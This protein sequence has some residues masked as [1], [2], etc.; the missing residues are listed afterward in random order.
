M[1]TINN[2]VL[3]N[4]A[5]AGAENLWPQ[6]WALT[7][8]M[9]KAGWKY[10]SSGDGSTKDTSRDPEDD[11]WGSGL[12][13]GVSGSDG[14]LGATAGGRITFTAGSGT[15]F[16]S[17][18]K[19]RFLSITGGFLAVNNHY[20]QIE[21]VVSSTV[22]RL[23]ARNPGFTPTATGETNNGALNYE[24]FD[25]TTETLPGGLAS[26]NAWILMQGPSVIKVPIT[27]APG[28]GVGGL[29]FIRGENISH[30]GT[31]AE[32]EILGWTFSTGSSTGY[33]V[34]LPRVIGTGSA[35]YGWE[36]GGEITGDSSGSAADQQG[37]G[38]EYRQQAVF[39]KAANQNS[40]RI[41]H[42]CIEPVGETA[43]DYYTL[44]QSAGCTAIVP[45]GGGGTG[46]AFP[47][48]GFISCG[49]TT[50]TNS[51]WSGNNGA[52]IHGNA[53]IMCADA[54]WE[55]DYSA[56]GT[57]QW[58][59]A[60]VSTVSSPSAGRGFYR[61]DDTEPGDLDPFIVGGLCQETLYTATPRTE[62]NQSAIAG[63]DNPFNTST[64]AGWTTTVTFWR[65]WRRRGLATGDNFQT[66]EFGS[67]FIGQSTTAGVAAVNTEDTERL[68]TEEDD[69]K[70]RGPLW[71]VSV[72]ANAK[73]RKGTVRHLSIVQGGN[74]WDTYD[75]GR[76]V[77]LSP[78]NGCFVASPW[79]ETS[80]PYP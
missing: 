79:D 22:V 2:V 27:A 57:W 20:H 41:F 71:V 44:S 61:C 6:I 21:E 8:A 9:K 58:Y 36:D 10:L 59:A 72:E 63:A 43:D 47:T 28:P 3:A 40:G 64:Q 37:D 62:A 30:D 55:Q 75:G 53:Q 16:S 7:R 33:L 24:V 14:T 13:T 32:G 80:V 38:L 76:F 49:A 35:P 51:K 74:A 45:P 4:V 68:A 52:L 73:M 77:Q 42:Q 17:G 56:D 1:S 23:D 65:G 46:N 5:N 69:T 39:C 15:P 26:V 50:S 34:V 19:G 18:D 29:T 48:I 11:E 25:P 54:I 67:L 31:G 70:V 60:T 12:T 78:T 66:F